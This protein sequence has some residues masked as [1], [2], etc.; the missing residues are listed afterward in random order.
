MKTL[1]N[2]TSMPVLKSL[3]LHLV[4]VADCK[5]TATLS[6]SLEGKALIPSQSSAQEVLE[7][8]HI[9]AGDRGEFTYWAQH[10]LGSQ[11]LSFS[12]SVLSELQDRCWWWAARS[13]LG[14]VGRLRLGVT[15]SSLS[16]STGSPPS[17]RCVAEEHQG[18]WPLVLTLIRRAL[19][20]AGFLLTYG[21]IWLYYTRRA[22]L[23]LHWEG[24]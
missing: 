17:C 24:Q 9:G 19:M 7:L 14:A 18:S 15:A 10:P 3:S 1:S 4:C 2:H 22:A 6:W 8:P 12:L 16:S 11:H 21:L 13:G 5:P 20:G 23:S